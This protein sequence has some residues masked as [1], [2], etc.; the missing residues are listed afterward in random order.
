MPGSEYYYYYY[1]FI[2]SRIIKIIK[3]IYVYNSLIT[4]KDN[5]IEQKKT[6]ENK[7]L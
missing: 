7:F 2:Y 3:N 5:K 4:N 6:N 1:N